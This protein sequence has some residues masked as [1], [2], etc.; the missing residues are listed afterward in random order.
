MNPVA[1]KR[2]AILSAL[3]CIENARHSKSRSLGTLDNSLGPEAAA[4][5]GKGIAEAVLIIGLRE[6]TAAAKRA[7]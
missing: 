5:G 1:R 4:A 2:A 7:G 6:I 3:L